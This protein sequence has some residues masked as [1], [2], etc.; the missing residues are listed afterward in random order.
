MRRFTAFYG[1]LAVSLI[2][3]VVSLGSPAAAVVANSCTVGQFGNLP[4]ATSQLKVACTL[5]TATALAASPAKTEDF[6]EAQWHW[7]AARTTA[8]DGTM[9][10]GATTTISSASA[11]FTLA[12]VNHGIS[13]P[14]IPVRAFIKSVSN[15]TTANINLAGGPA[16]NAVWLIEN[17]DARSV[18][19]GIC[20]TATTT[21]TSISANFT[22]ADVGKSIEGPC[23]PHGTTIVA[24]QNAATATVSVAT[25]VGSTNSLFTIGEEQPSS[26]TREV[27][28][29]A[30]KVGQP[31]VTS[32]SAN[33]QTSD[34]GLPI[35][36][37]CIP[38][39]AYITAVT[40]LTATINVAA[41]C[42][43]T[44]IVV[45]IGLP[46]RDSPVS[47]EVM[48]QIGVEQDLNPTLSLANPDLNEGMGDDPCTANTPEGLTLQGQWYNPGEFLGAG[49]LGSYP[50]AALTSP[51]VAQ[52]AF[53][54][55]A[56][57]FAAYVLQVK[58]AKAGETQSAAHYDV[59]VPSLLMSVAMCPA[60]AGSKGAAWTFQYNGNTES[61]QALAAGLGTPGTQTVRE[62]K[63]FVS[64][65][66]RKVTTAYTHFN[67]NASSTCIETYPGTPDFSCNSTPIVSS[68]SS[69]DPWVVS[70]GDS[71]ISGEAGRW[72][73]NTNGD[74]SAIDAL[75]PA[76]YNDDPSNTREALP[77]CH[78]SK[79]AEVYIGGGINGQNL[80]CSGALSYTTTPGGVFKPGLDFYNDGNGHLG[81][82]LMLQQFA[83][84]H[85]V[86]AVAV[87]IGGNDFGFSDIIQ[88]CVGDWVRITEHDC[89]NDSAATNHFSGA[90]VAAVTTA[91]TTA[92]G[93]VHLAM[94]NAGYADSAYKIMV[95]LYPSPIPHYNAMRYPDS[96]YV[97]Q[98]QG[99]CG[100]HDVD[101]DWLNDTGLLT[102]NNSVKAAIT[103]SA[104]TNVVTL[105]N[106]FA[107]VGHRL[108][109]SSDKLLED[110]G[111]F[112]SW[113]FPGS[114]DNSE[115]VNQIRI[116]QALADKYPLLAPFLNSG[117]PYALQEDF[118]PN[119][120]G[121]LALRSCLRQAYARFVAQSSSGS[122]AV[123]ELQSIG[124]T[125]NGEP[126]M[127]SH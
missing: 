26:T 97:R 6:S 123:C 34:I 27:E 43:A 108:C 127:I 74:Y 9:L 7:G 117:G 8:P 30:T 120:W 1:L 89:K 91:I 42:T 31:K 98:S 44:A 52:V 2:G 50:N 118:H 36:G 85:S 75:G 37:S 3:A 51:A 115:W 111:G 77:L 32:S 65:V 67:F 11:H 107:F 119:Y 48:A 17:S 124:M 40:T 60:S 121:Q 90:N 24:R 122:T 38:V 29:G 82:A 79:S 23:F 81:Q 28:D 59:V 62:L 125:A 49:T 99:G 104:L 71:F 25:K 58:A 69:S 64:G 94:Q 92:L 113:M 78:R 19:D 116:T 87:S 12:D 47:G 61:Q 33:F 22:A 10:S 68:G 86:K 66:A 56:V 100:I 109:E 80:A 46:N 41:G 15:G 112:P 126:I 105:D 35:T 102:I 101:L 93:N 55:A 106:T 5:T 13:G 14:G 83:Q 72:A 95:Q 53:K 76:A 70:V 103:A 57:T 73:G 114:V 54:T 18:V 84:S 16:T 4:D 21:I 88:T 39:G 96:G 20:T 63:D 45:T 110:Q